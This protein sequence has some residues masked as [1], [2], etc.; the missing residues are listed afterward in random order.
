MEAKMYQEHEL[1]T[2]NKEDNDD[3]DAKYVKYQDPNKQV[4]P[5]IVRTGLTI[6]DLGLFDIAAGTVSAV[7]DLWLI[8]DTK[9]YENT[10]ENN[11][12]DA[13]PWTLPNALEL[14]VAAYATYKMYG[15]DLMKLNQWT[16][17]QVL[18]NK[19]DIKSFTVEMY[20]LRGVL[21][22]TTFPSEDPFQSIYFIIKLAMD[23][24]PGSEMTQFA[25]SPGI[26]RHNLYIIQLSYT[27]VVSVR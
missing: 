20:T 27:Y 25:P 4:T 24:T 13:L 10:F 15:T 6:Y 9:I 8:Y 19:Y 1:A 5:L 26:Y 17:R 11:I 16:K 7:F 3:D 22:L 23:G 12:R 14:N 2:L 21:K 18:D